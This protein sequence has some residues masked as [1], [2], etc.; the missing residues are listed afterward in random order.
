MLARVLMLFG[1]GAGVGVAWG[2][3][4]GALVAA[5]C[6]GSALGAGLALCLG[7]PRTSSERLAVPPWHAVVGAVALGVGLVTMAQPTRMLG[8]AWPTVGR[9][10]VVGEGPGFTLAS[11]EPASDDKDLIGV[12]TR[13]RAQLREQFFDPG[14]DDCHVRVE[15]VRG[16]R[17]FERLRDVGVGPYGTYG[18]SALQGPTVVSAVNAGFGGLTHH[19]TYHYLWCTYRGELPTWAKEGMAT[20]VEKVIVTDGEISFGYR[21]PMRDPVVRQVLRKVPVAAIIQQGG[22][23]NVMQSFFLFLHRRG[24]LKPMMAALKDPGHNGI[25]ALVGVTNLGPQELHTQFTT[26]LDGEARDIPLLDHSVAL[27]GPLGAAFQQRV[28]QRFRWDE[29]WRIWVDR[30]AT[31]DVVLYP[32]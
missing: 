20:F 32:E 22:D 8:V 3:S 28:A 30:H 16:Q 29:T 18:H 12:I 11:D 27:V 14:P 13:F 26:W 4:H 17:L 24:W 21:H 19:L 10:Y 5:V 1:V 23:Q 9:T 7:L 25:E 15:Y 6:V 31:K 2:A